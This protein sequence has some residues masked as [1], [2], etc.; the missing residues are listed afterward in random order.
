MT[1][2]FEARS[3]MIRRQVLKIFGAGF[4]VYGPGDEVLAYCQQK[5]F[6][7]KEDIR[8]FQEEAQA[9]PL[10]TIKARQAIDFSAAYDIV[11][12]TTGVKVG[13]ARRKGLRS[14]MRDAWEV[15]DENDAPIGR[16][17][18]DSMGKAMARRFLSNLI[19]QSF[20]L[21]SGVQFKQRFNPFIYKLEVRIQETDIDPRLVFGVAVLIAAI[22]GRQ[23]S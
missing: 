4:H 3:Y 18:E 19:P 9:T 10:L 21:G 7:L 14:I 1:A 16:L 2:V 5:A 22:E 8:V 20:D 6:K 11:D 12:A 15:L 13:A 23:Q 17:E